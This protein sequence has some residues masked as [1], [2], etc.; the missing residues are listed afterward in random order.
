MARFGKSLRRNK[1]RRAKNHTSSLESL[2]DRRLLVFDANYSR[3]CVCPEQV[4][5]SPIHRVGVAYATGNASVSRSPAGSGPGIS[6]SS[7]T[8]PHPI[9]QFYDNDGL[10]DDNPGVAVSSTQYIEATLYLS[11]DG[12][13]DPG[14]PSQTLFIGGNALSTSDDTLFTFQIDATDVPTGRYHTWFTITRHGGGPSLPVYNDEGPEV[15]IV[16]R[17]QSEFGNRW[18]LDGLDRLHLQ[19]DTEDDYPDGALLVNGSGTPF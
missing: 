15:D 13:H 16:N 6:N 14:D 4:E 3:Y 12:D 5:E 17:S 11:V 9:V 18:W 19:T 7:G 10:G 1:V 2:E 8:N